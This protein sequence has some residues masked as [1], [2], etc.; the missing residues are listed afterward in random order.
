[1]GIS[2][3]SIS[4]PSVATPMLLCLS[5]CAHM[6]AP[7]NSQAWPKSK[8]AQYKLRPKLKHNR[9]PSLHIGPLAIKWIETVLFIWR[10]SGLR[11]WREFFSHGTLGDFYSFKFEPALIQAMQLYIH[12][13]IEI[14]KSPNPKKNPYFILFLA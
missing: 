11:S 3:R 13:N 14:S 1:M 2:L 8:L 4:F 9:K 5:P 12:P 10:I 7:W 6:E